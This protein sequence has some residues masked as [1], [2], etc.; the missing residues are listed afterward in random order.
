M[1]GSILGA[2]VRR[3]EDPRLLRGQGAYV[4]DLPLP[5]CLHAVFVRSPVPHARIIGVERPAGVYVAQDLELRP[6]LSF[7]LMP[8]AFARPPLAGEVVR[9][10]G[11]AVAVAVAE[12]R[13]AAADLAAAVQVDYDPLPVVSDPEAAASEGSPLLFPEAATN[14]A[15]TVEAGGEGDPLEGAEVV[16]RQRFRNQRLAAVPMEGNACAAAPEGAGLVVWASTQSPFQV[17]FAVAEAVG[18]PEDQVRAVA[19]DVG[20]GFGAKLS[21]YPEFLVIA[22][23]AWK[24]KRPVKWVETR[25]EG[26]LALNH[27]RALVQDVELGAT[28]EGRLVGLRVQVTADAGAYAILGAFLPFYGGQMASGAYAIPR[29]E[30]RS[31]SVVTNTTPVSAYRGAGRPEAAALIERAMDLLAQEL[32]LDPA[33]LRR[34]NLVADFPYQTATMATYDSGDY[35]RALEEALRLAGYAELRREQAAR[36]ASGSPRLL[37][38]GLSCYVE[39]TAV[40]ITDE[41]GSVELRPDGRALVLA[42]TASHGQG[43]GTAYAQIVAD[44]LGLPLDRVE[45]VEADT[46]RVPRGDGT[47]GSRSIQLAGSALAKAA[48]TVR[49]QVLKLAADRLEARAQDLVLAEGQVAVAG[50]PTRALTLGE[51]AASA[52]GSLKASQDFNQGDQTYPFG[53]HLAVVEVDVETGLVTHLRHIAVD[54]C[55]RVINPLLAEGQI[56]GGVAQGAAQALFEEVVY[57]ADGTPRTTSLLDYGFPTAAEMPQLETAF[58]ETPTLLNPLGAK[59]IGESG[60]IGATPAVWNAVLDA[61]SHL[62]VRHLDMPLTPDRV[63]AALRSPTRPGA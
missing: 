23:L 50:V 9:F 6:F 63:W 53:C 49:E 14:V 21:V 51:L 12:S 32:E 54:D 17:R 19:P 61:L 43:H 59:G 13:E 42:G 40:G 60:T 41:F 16:V 7:Q 55:G 1:A 56:H 33:E 20:G 11:D 2:S 3:L 10:A 37:G 52:A 28:R 24:L 15:F 57:D 4:D 22:A 27:G 48:D 62:G 30:Y 39:V 35:L 46:A 18:L 5:G 29:I 38:I 36:R 45:V 47:S 26:F 58:T 8:E 44:R 25:S 34:R 31:Q